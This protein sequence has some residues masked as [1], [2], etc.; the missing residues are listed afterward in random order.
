MA[1]EKYHPKTTSLL[2]QDNVAVLVRKNQAQKSLQIN[3]KRFQQ[4]ATEF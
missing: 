2:S 4:V 3:P 1:H